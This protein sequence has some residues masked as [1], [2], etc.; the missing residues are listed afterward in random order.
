MKPTGYNAGFPPAGNEPAGCPQLNSRPGLIS[1]RKPLTLLPILTVIGLSVLSCRKQQEPAAGP[2]PPLPS[3]GD[4]DGAPEYAGSLACR[5]CHSNEFEKWK[6]SHHAL[7]ETRFDPLIHGP[8]FE[9]GQKV[10]HG[11]RESTVGKLD[12]DYAIITEGADGKITPFTP[13]RVIGKSPLWQ[14]VVGGERGRYQVTALSYDPHKHEWFDVYGDEDRRPHE[15]G[16]WA[17][18]GM[19][20]NSMCGSCHTTDYRKNY[21][22]DSDSYNT[23]FSELGVGCEGCH[24]PYR[25]H[26]H[27]MAAQ[28]RTT[29][30]G[31]SS[32]AVSWPP[33]SF[34]EKR[35]EGQPAISGQERNR[36]DVILDTCGSCHARRVDLTGKFRPGEK[37]LDHYRPVIPDETEVYYEDGQVHEEDYEYTSFIS[38]RMHA[39]GVRC[40]HCHDPHTSKLRAQG[41]DLCLGCH[42]GKIDPVTHSHHDISKPGGQCANCHMPL[43]TYMQRHPRRDHGFTIP[44]PTLTRDY[45]IPNACNRC[46]ED[47]PVKWAIEWT[48]KWYGK[49]MNRH[50]QR[51]ARALAEARR[52]NEG[53]DKDLLALLNTENSKFWRSAALGLSGPWLQRNPGLQR[54]LFDSLA[55]KDPL[56]RTTA[57]RMTETLLANQGLPQ[58]IRQGIEARLTGLLKDPVRSVRI[59]AAWALRRS[60][61]RYSDAGRELNDYLRFNSDQPT[62]ALQIGVFHLDRREEE[63]GNLDKAI[64]WME[65]AVTWD[66]NSPFLHQSLAIAYSNKGEQKEAIE[67]LKR[68]HK[69]EPDEAMYAYNLALGLSEMERFEEAV[70]YLELTVQLDEDF[71]RAWYNLALARS[72][73]GKNQEAIDTLRRAEELE[74]GN[75]DYIYTRATILRDMKRYQ[76]AL[77]AVREAEKLAPGAPLLLQFRSSLHKELGQEAEARAAWEQYRQAE[78]LQRLQSQGGIPGLERP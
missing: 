67:S 33:K 48:G 74:P 10:Q 19:T 58:P 71:T 6:A 14:A 46:H 63:T 45:D 47:K 24:G 60:L 9:P 73:I 4:E 2:T 35:P 5:S 7:A 61:S 65:K 32:V 44:D 39:M 40:I 52:A 56:V 38:S 36:L 21:D 15:W 49:R 72:R 11:K 30:Q 66:P 59:D 75:V 23:K 31:V 34:L 12:G 53:A 17:N 3:A 77:D 76:D 18:R 1:Q 42:Q 69:L 29:P 25:R 68:A 55:D 43:T 13:L 51:R 28:G 50:T 54:A 37:F 41:N 27:E 62:G 78:A 22:P 8:A 57:A 26:A 70:R 64:G 20:W 16:F